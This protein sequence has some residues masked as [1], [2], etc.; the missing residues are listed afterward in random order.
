MT[1]RY[2]RKFLLG[3]IVAAEAELAKLRE[4]LRDKKEGFMTAQEMRDLKQGD[5]VVSLV[6]G[7]TYMVVANYGNRVTAVRIADI[8]NPCEWKITARA[9][10]EPVQ[11]IQ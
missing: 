2:T 9:N 6:T 5:V 3:K 8:T 7:L 1:V 4:W 11:S 10:T